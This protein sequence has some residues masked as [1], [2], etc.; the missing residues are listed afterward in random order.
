MENGMNRIACRYSI[1][2]FLPYSETGEFA[3]VGVVVACPETG[4][5]DYKL[6]NRR[7]AR[8]TGFFD[9][10]GGSVYLAA[11]K[12]MQTELERFKTTIAKLPATPE[13]ADAIR[14]LMS[15]LT[16]PRE[17]LI[18]FGP[19]R[20]A[21][22]T[23]PAH[24]LK[25]LFDHYVD[26]AFATPEYVETT[27]GRR[28]HTLLKDLKLPAPFKNDRVGD[29]QIH[30]TFPLVQRVD[31]ELRKVI[32]PFHLAQAEANAIYAHGDAWL[33]KV[34]RL[35]K[36]NLLPPDVLFAVAAPPPTAVK[37]FEAYREICVELEEQ[38]VKLIGKED[39]ASIVAFAE[40]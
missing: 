23:Q 28:I 2:Q 17:A 32:K 34:R 27:I 24:Q 31:G 14:H 16:H 20:P 18:R 36:R 5:F 39:E 21:L 38:D 19:V 9:E 22:T 11:V 4:Y 13:R 35:R 33:Q 25:E 6:Q 30:A 29:E 7:Y 12:V 40:A 3:N 15:A 8:I 10:L 37:R 26:R 1:V